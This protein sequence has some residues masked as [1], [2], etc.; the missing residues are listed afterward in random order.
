MLKADAI[1]YIIIF[2]NHV[3][4]NPVLALFLIIQFM[5]TGEGT[6][7]KKEQKVYGEVGSPPGVLPVMG[8]MGRFCLKGVPFFSLQYAEG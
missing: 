6:C 7:R 2:R 1:K 5:G 3:S 4:C 8:Y